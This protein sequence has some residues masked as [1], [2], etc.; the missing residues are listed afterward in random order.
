MTQ[1]VK[2]PL[3]L[4]A[5]GTILVMS[6]SPNQQIASS[7]GCWIYK[8][9]DVSETETKTEV[10]SVEQGVLFIYIQPCR[11]DL[12]L[13]K[14]NVS[15]QQASRHVLSTSLSLPS[16]LPSSPFL[17]SLTPSSPIKSSPSCFPPKSSSPLKQHSCA[18]WWQHPLIVYSTSQKANRSQLSTQQH[19]LCHIQ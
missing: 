15:R 5:K 11:C 19:C 16:L 12:S 8:Y 9:N 3:P 6:W 10:D 4:C 1:Q 18:S 13:W 7:C 17:S 2:Y 14:C